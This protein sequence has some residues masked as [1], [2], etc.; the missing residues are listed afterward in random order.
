MAAAINYSNGSRSVDPATSSDSGTYGSINLLSS[1]TC[2]GPNNA[3]SPPKADQCLSLLTQFISDNQDQGIEAWTNNNTN[4]VTPNRLPTFFQ[5]PSCSLEWKAVGVS[6]KKPVY[7]EYFKSLDLVPALVKVLDL[8]LY[9]KGGGDT[10]IGGTVNFRGL[11]A[12]DGAP[13][14]ETGDGS[15]LA[16]TLRERY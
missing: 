6:S 2:L 7:T 10:H 8:C 14:N 4:T 16:L 1:I 13:A 9:A 12:A 11:D 5:S 3:Q 15:V